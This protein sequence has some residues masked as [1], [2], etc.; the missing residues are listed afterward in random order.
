VRAIVTSGSLFAYREVIRPNGTTVCGPSG[1][2]E[3][4]CALDTT[5]TYTILIEDVVGTNTGGYAVAVQR[6]N[7]PVG[8]T[9]LTFGAAPTAGTVSAAGQTNCYT[10]S[11]TAGDEIRL[12]LITTSGS[13]S[14]TQEVLRPN[15][16]TICGP[17]NTGDLTCPLTDTGTHALL[18]EDQSG[19]NTGAY[20]I[21]VR[22]LNSTTGCT[23]VTFGA[24]PVTGAV[25]VAGQTNCHSFS[26]TAGDKVRLRAIV[27]SGTLF[28]SRE[29]IRPNGT[30]V[31]G[32]SGAAEMTCALDATGTYTILIEDVAGTNAGGYSIAIQRLD[33]PVGCTALTVG[34]TATAGSIAA[35]AQ[36][37][38]YTFSATAGQ[39]ILAHLVHTSGALVPSQ[40]VIRPN[41]STT[42]GPSTSDLTCTLD[43]TGTFTIVVEDQFGT[44]KGAYTIR[45]S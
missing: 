38:C 12:R 16:T 6:L 33:S 11:G 36:M 14:P 15:G 45:V 10:F 1:A 29:V 34:G 8:C 5:G 35:D 43:T 2:A 31:C 27:T 26:G 21:S 40:E 7:G 3:V 24:A 37:N 30:T 28:V 41:G 4:T 19:I 32:P 25:T 42:C 20:V 13:V 44:N 23:A 9:V 39:S 22:R 17:S 18:I